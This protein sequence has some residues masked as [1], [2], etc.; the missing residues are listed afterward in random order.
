MAALPKLFLNLAADWLTTRTRFLLRSRARPDR[1]QQRTLKRLLA[2]LAATTRGRELGLLPT[3]TAAE[4][5]QRVP[6]GDHA[7]L[8]PWIAR[9]QAGEADVLWPGRCEHFTATA[10]TTT[11]R[12]RLLPLTPAQWHHVCQATQAALLHA[13][14]RAGNV[15]AIRGRTL[16][17]GGR[18]LAL[19]DLAPESDAPL[20]TVADPATL[21]ALHKPRWVTR[22]LFEPSA[23]IALLP[24][25]DRMVER[26]LQRT[27]ARPLSLIAGSPHW[28]VPFARA[29]LA[30]AAAAKPDRPGGAP[31][32]L[33]Q[34]WP[35]LACLVHAG[36]AGE[37]RLATLRQLAGPRVLLHEVYAAAEGIFA[38]QGPGSRPGLRLLPRCGIYFEF[39]PVTD[40][41]PARPGDAGPK[42]VPL[43]EV[44][45]GVDYLL[46][47]TTP[48]GLVRHLV[49]DV[50]RFTHLRPHLI[51]PRGSFEL[52]LNTWG[53]NLLASDVTDALVKI[54]Q[55]RKWQVSHFHVA[56]LVSTT[57]LG[58]PRGS[59]EWWIELKAGSVST[60]TGPT[61]AD[62]LDRHLQNENPLYAE[63]RRSG[64]FEPPIVRLVM[65]GAFEHWLRHSGR[66]GG[67]HKVPA[68]RNDR[69]L[70]DELARIA[71]F[72][73]D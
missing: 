28:L 31:S 62:L 73:Q 57:E 29:A 2:S 20:P 67:P 15:D 21:A 63:K 32:C 56:P 18:T 50:V 26:I 41:D 53:E 22:L 35:H 49:G 16:L 48:A 69:R 58:R 33:Q 1:V 11:L 34:V 44:T 30:D 55:S 36:D 37:P 43:A 7:V 51:L 6:L 27:R 39:L 38:A 17:L 54:C 8:A 71:R 19:S 42:A 68:T 40:F 64:G 70:A 23:S 45:T 14:A 24:D 12:P 4:F 13:T 65:P 46:V 47:V 66:W 52:R 25:W 59:H 60:P 5:R 72:S 61:L 9:A 10:G 3:L